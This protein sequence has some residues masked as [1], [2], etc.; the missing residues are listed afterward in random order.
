MNKENYKNS[1]NIK[2]HEIKLARA[3]RQDI[4]LLFLT[5]LILEAVLPYIV[6]FSNGF[7]S[8]PL[9]QYIFSTAFRLT[10]WVTAFYFIW[11]G[12]RWIRI[13]TAWFL[14]LSSIFIALGLLAS[15]KFPSSSSHLAFGVLYISYGIFT[16]TFLLKSNRIRKFVDSQRLDS[17]TRPINPNRSGTYEYDVAISYAGEDR[18]IAKKLS[19][20]LIDR[21]LNVF[22]DRLNEDEILGK[23][24]YHYLQTIYKDSAQ[25]CAILIS[26]HYIKKPWTLHELEQ[27]QTRVFESRAAGN[28]EYLLP[29]RIDDTEIPGINSIT[30]Y[31]DIR[32]KSLE[33][34]A[35]IIYKKLLG[36]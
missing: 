13:L 12:R 6:L 21:G 30:G 11:K 27:I 23:N 9:N 31:I 5:V 19:D 28:K 3:G 14:I 8:L 15:A 20:M 29:L 34:V 32:E 7:S 22:Y 33:D 10:L 17:Q 35:D 25:T 24:L 16:G 4:L 2:S 26:K 36:K 1:Q 18:N